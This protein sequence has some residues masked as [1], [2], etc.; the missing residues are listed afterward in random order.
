MK[1]NWFRGTVSSIRPGGHRTVFVGAPGKRLMGDTGL[2]LPERAGPPCFED[3]WEAGGAMP[4]KVRRVIEGE[5]QFRGIEVVLGQM[6]RRAN[7]SVT[8]ALILARAGDHLVAL[9]AIDATCSDASL[10][11][12]RVGDA[13][14]RAQ[15]F[16][17]SAAILILHSALIDPPGAFDHYS[18]MTAARGIPSARRNVLY[19]VDGANSIPVFAAWIDEG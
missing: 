2:S 12:T 7:R 15:R 19:L 13:A 16:C 8:E 10:T 9:L 3:L 14:Q 11:A 5:P 6:E 1:Q 18:A 4:A 17:A